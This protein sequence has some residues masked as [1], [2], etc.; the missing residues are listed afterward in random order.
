[1]IVILISLT[2]IKEL[3]IRIKLPRFNSSKEK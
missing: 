1:M 3:I 2:E